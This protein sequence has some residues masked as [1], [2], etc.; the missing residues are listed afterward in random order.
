MATN[1]ETKADTGSWTALYS[2]VVGNAAAHRASGIRKACDRNG[3]SA[4]RLSKH[5]TQDDAHVGAVDALIADA[6]SNG[7][8]YFVTMSR[9][10]TAR[11]AAI[12]VSRAVRQQARA[13]AQPSVSV[14][15]TQGGARETGELS[16]DTVA[17]HD[18][19][20]DIEVSEEAAAVLASLPERHRNTLVILMANAKGRA[21]AVCPDDVSL[22]AWED[23]VSTARQAFRA[24]W[25][26][27]ADGVVIRD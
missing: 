24:V 9:R 10:P 19:F 2:K 11:I 12:M 25:N 4:I 18:P 5:V 7:T 14:T 20:A 23:R 6:L 21:S 3:T 17:Q 1:E 26:M 16:N 13:E 8:P 22:S 27:R 15:G